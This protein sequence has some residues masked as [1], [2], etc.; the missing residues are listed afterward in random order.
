ML[1]FQSRSLNFNVRNLFRFGQL[2]N[3]QVRHL[4]RKPRLSVQF[5]LVAGLFTHCQR[6]D[7]HEQAAAEEQSQTKLTLR[8]HVRHLSL[9]PPQL[10][11]QPSAAKVIHTLQGQVRHIQTVL[12]RQEVSLTSIAHRKRCSVCTPARFESNHI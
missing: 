11:H 8:L 7:K 10:F 3:L 1:L 4:L 6:R 12:Q 2:I 9:Q 5:F